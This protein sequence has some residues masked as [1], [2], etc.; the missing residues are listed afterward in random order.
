MSPQPREVHLT[1]LCFIRGHLITYIPQ[2]YMVLLTIIS[3][4]MAMRDTSEK[5][6]LNYYWPIHQKQHDARYLY[7]IYIKPN[8]NLYQTNLLDSWS[9]P[10]NI[11][12]LHI[13]GQNLKSTGTI[14]SVTVYVYNIVYQNYSYIIYIHFCIGSF[15]TYN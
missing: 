6:S 3:N 2:S 1:S 15:L 8:T 11:T 12:F 4:T 7:E 14:I 5:M 9:K 13:C 10:K